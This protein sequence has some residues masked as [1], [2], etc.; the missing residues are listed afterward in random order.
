M[1]TYTSPHARLKQ[2]LSHQVHRSMKRI[3]SAIAFAFIGLNAGLG[4]A[5]T[6]VHL[7]THELPP[8]SYTNAEGKA[9]GVA[10][11][12]VQC[13]FDRIKLPLQIEFLPWARAQLHAKQN[14]AH[15]FFAASQSAERDSWAV[16]SATIAPQQW[17]WYLRSDSPLDP[18]SAAFKEKATVAGFVGANM[19]DWMRENGYRVEATPY[20]NPQ[21]LETLLANRVDAILANQLVMENLLAQNPIRSPLRSVL[22]QDKPLSIYFSKTFLNNAPPDFLKR[23]N[24]AITACKN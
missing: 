3:G 20:T 5:Q 17:R 1:N 7:T 14:L 16:M 11:K 21:L 13:A 6:T 2:Q 15:G 18:K 23:V 22:E 12:R 10:V 8:Y 4:L 9:A 19:L 24:Q